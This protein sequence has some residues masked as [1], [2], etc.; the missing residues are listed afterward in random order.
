[1]KNNQEKILFRI[2]L[3]FYENVFE[4]SNGERALE[5]YKEKNHTLYYLI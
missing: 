1:M 5:V 4:A 3:M 2:Y